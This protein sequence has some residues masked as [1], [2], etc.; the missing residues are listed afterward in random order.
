MLHVVLFIAHLAK[1]KKKQKTKNHCGSMPKMPNSKDG[2]GHWHHYC[3]ELNESASSG[4]G[5][6][7]TEISCDSFSDVWEAGNDEYA[8]SIKFCPFCGEKLEKS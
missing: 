1:K 7:I 8:S 3:A 4:H 6:A 5:P 2:Y